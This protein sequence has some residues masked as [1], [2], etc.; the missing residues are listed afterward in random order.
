MAVRVQGRE[1]SSNFGTSLSTASS[2]E[3][4]R[5]RAVR[6]PAAWSL[7]IL[8]CSLCA[9]TEPRLYAQTSPPGVVST[10]DGN[11]STPTAVWLD[12]SDAKRDARMKWWRDAR[13]GMFVHWGVYAIPAGEWDGRRIDG[14]G[15]WIMCKA[16]IPTEEYVKLA[17]EFDPTSYDPAEWVAAAKQAGMRYIVITAK[18]HDGFCLFDTKRTDWDVVDATPYGKDLLVPLAEECRKQGLRFGLYYSIIDWHH[19]SQTPSDRGRNP[20]LMK[21]GQKQQYIQYMKGQLQELVDSCSPDLFWFDGEWP[22]WWTEQDGRDLYS[23]LRQLK[24]SLIVNNRVGKGRDGMRGL[25]KDEGRY[26][27]D[28]GTPEQQIPTQ[29]LAGID[30]EA[31]LTMNDTWGFKRNDHD[32]KDSDALIGSLVEAV[33]K[34]GNLLL[35]VGPTAD[36]KIPDESLKR[37]DDIGAW[38]ANNS[39]AIYGASAGPFDDLPYGRSTSKSMPDHKMI[40]VAIRQRPANGMLRLPVERGEAKSAVRL[41]D[42]AVLPLAESGDGIVIQIREDGPDSGHQVIAVEVR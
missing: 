35:N 28:F 8:A 31:C 14:N 37:L 19:P 26:V 5:C 11:S 22:N 18:H 7:L 39:R 27:G 33:S 16:D 1:G 42:G 17:A 25:S 9:P 6:S 23:Y 21:P 3:C 13:F 20:T 36:G 29:H 10:T 30:W 34:G 12:E 40:Y 2:I 24:P 38:M 32:W 4:G 15:E 41:A